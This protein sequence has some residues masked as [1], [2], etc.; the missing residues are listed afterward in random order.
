MGCMDGTEPTEDD[1]DGNETDGVDDGGNGGDGD[2]EFE[3]GE[4]YE[5]VQSVEEG[6]WPV[7]SFDS[8]NTGY[9][10]SADGPGE[11]LESDVQMEVRLPVTKGVSVVDGTVY[12]NDGLDNDDLENKGS[13]Y[14]FDAESGEALWMYEHPERVRAA[15]AVTGSTV[16]AVGMDDV[17]LALDASNGERR[18]SVGIGRASEFSSPTVVD[19]TVYVGSGDGLHAVGA[20]GGG[21]KWTFET[22][23]VNSTPA[24]EDG[25][26]Y[27]GSNDDN[28]YAADAESG[29]ELWSF[30]TGDR[31]VSSPAVSDGV[32][33]VGSRDET[34]YAVDAES[35]EPVWDEAFETDGWI[36]SS[37]AVADGVVYVGSWDNNVYAVDVESG[38]PVWEEPLETSD[39]V[40]DEVAVAGG[41]LY[42]TPL[43]T[44][45]YVVDAEDGSV[46]DTVDLDALVDGSVSSSGSPVPVGDAVYVGASQGV[47][48][49]R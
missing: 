16:Y 28:L 9:N 29:D 33:Y 31:V 12:V 30:G 48:A 26:V 49:L 40:I 7:Y 3:P 22:N 43:G 13:V 34:L 15:P 36:E 21:V 11:G 32:V 14:A 17:L 5:A 44:D 39:R 20:Y 35:G 41:N 2:E 18:W 38:E 4:P 47:H 37:P 8:V 23:T 24:V 46:S 1:G 19:G 10:P 45:L 42:V 6:D 25:V 27:F